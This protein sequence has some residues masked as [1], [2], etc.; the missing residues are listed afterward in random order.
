MV[1]F[2]TIILGTL[3]ACTLAC[4]FHFWR[5]GGFKWL[6]FDNVLSIVGFWLGHFIAGLAGWKF[7][8]LGPL[9]LG[10]SLIGALFLMVGIFWF[11]MASV[12]QNPK[13]Q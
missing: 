8:M 4:I 11:S 2:P 9:Y 13:K 12:D 5:G 6:V 1:V 3:M 10:G 7:L